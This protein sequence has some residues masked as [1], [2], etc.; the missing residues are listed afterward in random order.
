MKKQEENGEKEENS[1]LL[2]NNFVLIKDR[3][4]GSL[5]FNHFLALTKKRIITTKRDV[6]TLLFEIGIPILLVLI[7]LC[8]ML[9]SQILT[10]YTAYNLVLSKYDS[11]QTLLFSG[12]ADGSNFMNKI[13]DTNGTNIVNTGDASLQAFSDKVLN[14]RDFF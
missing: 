13:R 7:G 5:A 12:T 6:K 14:S 11:G 1:P 3:I 4:V 8:L 2:Q 10:D 9:V